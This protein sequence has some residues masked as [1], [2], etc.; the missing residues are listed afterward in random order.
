MPLI[1]F[2]V[3]LKLKQTEHCALVSADIENADANSNN[4]IF[5][6]E[7]AKLY[8]PIFTLLA[9]DNQKLSIIL[10]KGFER[11]VYWDEYETKSES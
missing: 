10:S 2:K 11:S 3:E 9:K 1:N 8:V 4:I 7:D 6:I 5:A